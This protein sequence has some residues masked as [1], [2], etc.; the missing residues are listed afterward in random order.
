MNIITNEKQYMGWRIVED[1]RKESLVLEELNPKV[2]I[3]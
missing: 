2:K 1:L 3:E